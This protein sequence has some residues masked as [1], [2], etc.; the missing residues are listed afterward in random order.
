M[1]LLYEESARSMQFAKD[2]QWKSVGATL[3][4]FGGLIAIAY[5]TSP[6]KKIGEYLSATS[7]LAIQ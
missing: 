6:D 2:H 5:M 7:I 3:F 1:R 4:M